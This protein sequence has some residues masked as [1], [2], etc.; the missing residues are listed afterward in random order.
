MRQQ[1]KGA[2]ESP[3]QQLSVREQKLLSSS[4]DLRHLVPAVGGSRNRGTAG[5]G[6]RKQ[7]KIIE[8][9]ITNKLISVFHIS[10]PETISYQWQFSLARASTKDLWSES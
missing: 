10:Y 1:E 7:K 3:T 2:Q 9:T 5:K 6:K 8:K 4:A